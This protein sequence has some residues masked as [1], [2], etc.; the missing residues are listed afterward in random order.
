M[1]RELRAIAAEPLHLADRHG[2]GNYSGTLDYIPGTALRGAFAMAYLRQT[3]RQQ[4]VAQRL[5]A[6]G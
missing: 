5:Q 1:K 4:Q 6:T 2:A 3:D